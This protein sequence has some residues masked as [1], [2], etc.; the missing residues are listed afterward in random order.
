ML[1]E[2]IEMGD[3]DSDSMQKLVEVYKLQDIQGMQDLFKEEGSDLDGH[4]DV[5]L[6]NRNKNWIPVIAEEMKKGSTFFAVGAGHL[7]GPQGVI[8]LLRE[9]GYKMTAIN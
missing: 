8:H 7:A 6:N 5:L 4:E 2:T 1:L 3:S 9:A